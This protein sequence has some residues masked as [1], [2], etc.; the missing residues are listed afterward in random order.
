M[1]LCESEPQDKNL[2]SLMLLVFTCFT[3]V[4]YLLVEPSLW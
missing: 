1:I 4:I 3:V 2:V